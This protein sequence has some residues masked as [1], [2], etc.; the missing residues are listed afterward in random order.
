[1]CS[2][3]VSAAACNRCGCITEN[4]NPNTTKFHFMVM[5]GTRIPNHEQVLPRRSKFCTGHEV[6]PFT[7]LCHIAMGTCPLIW[8]PCMDRI[9]LQVKKKKDRR[10]LEDWLSGTYKLLLPDVE[11]PLEEETDLVIV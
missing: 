11:R 3:G 6:G 1:M 4:R 7:K 9:L 5:D 10:R 8:R 2:Y